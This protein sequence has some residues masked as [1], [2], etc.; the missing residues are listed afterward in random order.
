MPRPAAECAAAVLLSAMAP[1]I[2]ANAEPTP[3]IDLR[4]LVLDDK[5]P[6][7][8]ALTAELKGSGTPCTT[9]DLTASKRSRIDAAFLSDTA[10]GRPRATYQA[11]VVPNDNP[12]GDGSAER[13]ALVAYEKRFGIRQVDA[14]TYARPAVGLGHPQN[15]GY[16]GSLDGHTA[17]V[18]AAGGSGPFGYLGGSVPFEDNDPDAAESY[19]YLS[20]PLENQADGATFTPYVEVPIPDS[21]ACGSLVGDYAHG[22]RREL[23]VAFV[24][25]QYQYQSQFRLLARGT[26]GWATQGIHLGADRTELITGEHSGLKTLPQQPSDHPNP[27][28]ALTLTGVTS[29]AS[30]ASREQEQRTLGP[31][32]TVPRHPMNIFYNA[33]R[34]A[35]Q[36][37][38]D[39]WVPPPSR[40]SRRNRSCPPSA[41]PAGSTHVR[42]PA[43]SCCAA[44]CS[45][46][47]VSAT[48]WA[49]PFSPP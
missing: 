9:V 23:V 19:G 21:S 46:C 4:V 6:A 39:N 20:V 32:T 34:A 44:R 47:P 35:E 1:A 8:A 48:P 2:G 22:G 13:A 28:S 18:T 14:Y 37:D 3:R 5:G 42:H 45:R 36:V 40:P 25:N 10:D 30:D 26:V 41:G 11:V 31:A 27:P 7:T 15:P 29:L 33:G 12:F 49:R 16:L 17:K 24:Y 38:E 43:R